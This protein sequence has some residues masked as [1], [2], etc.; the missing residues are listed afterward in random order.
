MNKDWLSVVIMR[1][2]H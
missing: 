2:R 1:K